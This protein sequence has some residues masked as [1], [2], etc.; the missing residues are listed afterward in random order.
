MS[1]FSKLFKERF[2]FCVCAIARHI[3]ANLTKAGAKDVITLFHSPKNPSSIR[4][5][6]LLKQTAGTA[7]ETATEDQASNHEHH[8]K[9][10]KE[11]F[12]LQVEEQQ[13]TA[14]QLQ[15]ILEYAGDSKAS[16]VV[17]G[18]SSISDA[19]KKARQGSRIQ[20]PLVVAW[21]KGKV[22]VGDNESE[23]LKMVKALPHKE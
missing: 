8:A 4:V 5:Y 13:P 2:A 17:E 20:T 6:T 18:A 22:V 11:E 14:D 3:S 9:V 10:S 23:I 15:S 1:M 19:V 21:N 7:A 16:S 12:E